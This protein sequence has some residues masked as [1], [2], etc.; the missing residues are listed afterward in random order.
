MRTVEV[1]K[2]DETIR[3][4]QEAACELESEFHKRRPRQLSAAKGA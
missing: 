2:L 4:M 1:S 3:G